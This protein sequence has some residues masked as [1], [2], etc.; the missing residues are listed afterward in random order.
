MSDIPQ[1]PYDLLWGERSLSSVAN[2]TR[3]DADAFMAVASTVHI[4]TS[5]EAF[6]LADANQALEHLR[7]G[8]L[9][10]SAVLL[11]H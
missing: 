6:P 3:E 4:Q 9:R 8:K 2:L 11:T 1:F 7:Q 5:F 10:G